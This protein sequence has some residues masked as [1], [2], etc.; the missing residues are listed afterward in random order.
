MH[1]TERRDRERDAVRDGKRGHGFHETARAIDENQQ[2]EDKK[3][4]VNSEPN[5]LDAQARVTPATWILEG[6]AL[7]SI[8]GCDGCTKEVD[9]LT[10]QQ[11]HPH[12]D[13]GDGCL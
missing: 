5:V 11:S 9:S 3:K 2:G 13:I 1:K 12:Q 4:M 6:A 7:N 8:H 10:V